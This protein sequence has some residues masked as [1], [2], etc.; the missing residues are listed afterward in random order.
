MG[1]RVRGLLSALNT[2]GVR[3]RNVTDQTQRA[4]GAKHTLHKASVWGSRNEISGGARKKKEMREK[5]EPAWKSELQT[6]VHLCQMF[7]TE[8]SN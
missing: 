6:M 7:S 2:C 3:A 5:R 1:A 4:G 8:Q